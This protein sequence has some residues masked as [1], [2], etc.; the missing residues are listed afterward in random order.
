MKI[1]GGDMSAAA[2]GNGAGVAEEGLRLV[3]VGVVG[4]AMGNETAFEVPLDGFVA[5][6]LAR[7][8]CCRV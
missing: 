4:E 6:R 2:G 3:T 8:A 7:S 5:Y 1:Y